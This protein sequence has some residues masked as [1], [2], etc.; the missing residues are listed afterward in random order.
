M[1]YPGPDSFAGE[2]YTQKYQLYT[3]SSKNYNRSKNFPIPFMRSLALIPKQGQ[4][5]KRKEENCKP[6]SLMNIDN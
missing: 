5:K 3:N 1:K 6:I 2:F 4:Y